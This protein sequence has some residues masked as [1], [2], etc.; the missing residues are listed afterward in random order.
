M[1]NI[2]IRRYYYF[3]LKSNVFYIL[4]CTIFAILNIFQMQKVWI[5]LIWFHW[6]GT[7]II[8]YPAILYFLAKTLIHFINPK[9][10]YSFKIEFIIMII[11]TIVDMILYY[12]LLYL[13][14]V[15]AYKGEI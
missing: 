14:V 4:L 7:Y 13:F 10:T 5:N 12:F 9:F 1:D 6:E 2:T 8:A 3:L 15:I 11:C